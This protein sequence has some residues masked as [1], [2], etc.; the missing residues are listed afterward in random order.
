MEQLRFVP[1]SI[2]THSVL[3]FVSFIVALTYYDEFLIYFFIIY[4]TVPC[5][6]RYA[7]SR[8]CGSR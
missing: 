3:D 8:T 5:P 7:D 1:A 6:I 4:A 2:A